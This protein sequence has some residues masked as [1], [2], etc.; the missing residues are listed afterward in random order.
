MKNRF[1]S[2]SESFLVAV[3][4]VFDSTKIEVM[5]FLP[6]DWK[7]YGTS[8]NFQPSSVRMRVVLVEDLS[9]VAGGQSSLS[10]AGPFHHLVSHSDY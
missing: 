7:S 3:K 10:V 1:T 9:R 2:H 6:A 5:D 4:F 8:A